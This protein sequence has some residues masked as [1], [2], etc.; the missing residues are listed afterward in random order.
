MG[1]HGNLVARFYPDH[2]KLYSAGW[3]TQT[4]KDRLNLALDIAGIYGYSVW[5]HDYQWY[6]GYLL[7]GVEFYDGMKIDYTGEVIN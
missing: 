6:Y 1:L 2:L 7:T 5:Q 4:T 3:Y